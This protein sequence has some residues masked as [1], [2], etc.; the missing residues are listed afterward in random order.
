MA[1]TKIRFRASSVP[2]R[3]G[4]LFLQVIHRRVTRRTVL[5]YRLLP[6]EWDAEGQTVVLAAAPSAERHQYLL[7]VQ[8]ALERIALQGMPALL[9]GESQRLLKKLPEG[10]PAW[11]KQAP[12]ALR[13]PRA[14]SV[15]WAALNEFD[16]E[17]DKR[18]F[19]LEPYYIRRSEAEE[20]WEKKQ[21]Q[22]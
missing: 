7:A 22:Q 3:Q 19:G 10:L 8:Q 5:S 12:E 4:A 18:I 2:G 20:L 15:A 9:L 17:A 14:S 13:M 1:T 11:L 21:Q 6:H 16:P